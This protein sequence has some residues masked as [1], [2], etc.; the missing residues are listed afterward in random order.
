M[1]NYSQGSSS[2][3]SRVKF[4]VISCS[5]TQWL[6]QFAAIRRIIRKAHQAKASRLTHVI[7]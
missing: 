6:R 7:V 1:T 4:A 3:A 2:F 5:P